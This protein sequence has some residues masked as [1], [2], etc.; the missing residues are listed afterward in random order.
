MIMLSSRGF[1]WVWWDYSVISSMEVDKVLLLLLWPFPKTS[2]SDGTLKAFQDSFE[3]GIWLKEQID[4][5]QSSTQEPLHQIKDWWPGNV[6][7]CVYCLGLC[8]AL[9][10]RKFVWEGAHGL[11]FLQLVSQSLFYPRW[12]QPLEAWDKRR[13]LIQ[14]LINLSGGFLMS[15]ALQRQTKWLYCRL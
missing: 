3:I 9:P 6:V 5:Y 15:H 11:L 10:F 8:K 4:F 12:S 14:F 2:G 1:F 13:S 7:A